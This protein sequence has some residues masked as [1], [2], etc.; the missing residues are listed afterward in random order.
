MWRDPWGEVAMAQRGRMAEP[1]GPTLRKGGQRRDQGISRNLE[2]LPVYKAGENLRV[3]WRNFEEYAFRREWDDK[4]KLSKVTGVGGYKKKIEGVAAE[5]LRWKTCVV[6]LWQLMGNFPR[7]EIEDD[8]TF[9]GT[10]LDQFVDSLPLSAEKG[11]WNDE[12]KR[13]RLM[14]RTKKSESE[15]VKRIVEERKAQEEGEEEDVP[16]R[17][18]R[19]KP[20]TFSKDRS[21]GS[22]QAMEEEKAK[23]KAAVERKR[24]QEVNRAPRAKRIEGRRSVEDEREGVEMERSE[25]RERTEKDKA[26]EGEKVEERKVEYEGSSQQKG[27][28]REGHINKE[29]RAQREKR[30]KGWRD[31]MIRMLQDDDL[32]VNSTSDVRFKRMLLSELV[33]SSKHSTN[34]HKLMGLHEMLDEKRTRLFE[35]Y[36]DVAKKLD[37]TERGKNEKEIRE[38]MEAVGKGLQAEL[39]GSTELFTQRFLDYIPGFLKE[40]SRLRTKEEE[41]DAHVTRLTEDLEGIRREI[42]NLKKGKEKL[43]KQVSALEVSLSQKSK[44]LEDEVAERKKMEK[45]VESLCSGISLQGEDM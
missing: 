14:E 38:D 44:E 1:S 9:D 30:K 7:D 11:G 41:R 10:N 36:A 13:K 2:E 8:L 26:V 25:K 34:L 33:V 21:R 28:A 17:N 18:L 20:R 23:K 19:S 43:L 27:E 15:E 12:E 22:D 24:G 16:L 6:R 35:E 5:C 39:K 3:F 42:E 45:K 4:M 37:E 31:Y 32:S 40:M 29:E